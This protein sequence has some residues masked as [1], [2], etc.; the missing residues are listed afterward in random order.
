MGSQKIRLGW[1]LGLMCCGMGFAQIAVEE[2]WSPYDYPREIPEGIQYHIIID[3]DTLWAISGRYLGD[4]LLWPQIYQAND[5]IKDPD[6]IYPGDPIFLNVGVVVTDTAIAEDLADQSSLDD[7]EQ[8]GDFSTETDDFESMDDFAEASQSGDEEG[9]ADVSDITSFDA[10]T[11][12]FVILPAGDRSDM[13]CSTYLYPAGSDVDALPFDFQVFGGEVRHLSTFAHNDVV[14]LNKGKDDGIKPGEVY[15]VRRPLKKVY[16]PEDGQFL[17]TAIDQIGKIKIVAVQDVNS[18]G[19]VVDSCRE[20]RN[21]DFLVPFEQ[22]PIPLITEL[23]VVNRF[24]KFNKQGSG[25]IVLVEDGLLAVGKGYLTN[26]DL[27]IENNV[28]PGDLFIIYRPNPGNDPKK[29]LKLP[30]VYL[31]HGVALKTLGRSSVMKIIESYTDIELGD[32]VVA[33]TGTSFQN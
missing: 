28:A 13:E 15:G 24:E 3:G 9:G 33:L 25:S 4:P 16:H 11:T 23:P 18:T 29:N 21:G 5:Y 19:L 8:S 26:I 2:H 17:G 10:D 32:K 20:I 31:G 22:E 6:L 30:D 1:I 7:S 14:Y 27:G 12:E